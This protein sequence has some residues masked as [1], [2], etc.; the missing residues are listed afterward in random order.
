MDGLVLPDAVTV[1]GVNLDVTGLT[2]PQP[3]DPGTYVVVAMRNEKPVTQRNAATHPGVTAT[4]Q[5]KTK[6]TTQQY[7]MWTCF[8]TGAAGMIVGTTTG[9]MVL[10]KHSNLKDAG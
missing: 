3:F 5:T 10:S 7:A 1:D 2:K 8:G 9:L 6:T 4:P